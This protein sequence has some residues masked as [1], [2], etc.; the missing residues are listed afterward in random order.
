L[1]KSS[2]IKNPVNR[3]KGA[4]K[5]KVLQRTE[6]QSKKG[7]LM[8]SVKLDDN[9]IYD[10]YKMADDYEL[11]TKGA[12]SWA[13]PIEGSGGGTSGNRED[14]QKDRNTSIERQ[15]ACRHTATLVAAFIQAR[16]T[17][18][19]KEVDALVSHYFSIWHGLI[20]DGQVGE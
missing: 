20:K 13:V 16:P 3:K 19:S 15:N 6:K 8:W 17:L 5:M 2:Q 18:T 10:A 11:R 14:A 4:K 12:Y 7:E 1:L 9:R